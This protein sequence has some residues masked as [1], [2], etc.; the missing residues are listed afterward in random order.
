MNYRRPW[1]RLWSL[2]AP[3]ASGRRRSS[4]C[5]STTR[6]AGETRSTRPGPPPASAYARRVSARRP[7]RCTRSLETSCA[8]RRFVNFSSSSE[9]ATSSL[10]DAPRSP[11]S[12]YTRRAGRYHPSRAR[13]T[14]AFSPPSTTAPSSWTSVHRSSPSPSA[15]RSPRARASPFPASSPLRLPRVRRYSS[16]VATT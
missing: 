9:V 12:L 8:S 13:E 2:M 3:R 5:P 16:C 10:A 11:P 7:T 14:S 4:S 1:R 6:D 15:L